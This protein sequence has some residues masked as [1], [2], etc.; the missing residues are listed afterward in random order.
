MKYQKQNALLGQ[1]GAR[2]TYEDLACSNSTKNI[3]AMIEREFPWWGELHGWWCTNPAYNSTW[4]AAD[5]GQNFTRCA[6][7]LFKLWPNPPSGDFIDPAAGPLNSSQLE[8]G[9]IVEG[10][11]DF[12]TNDNFFADD[13]ELMNVDVFACTPPSFN[14]SELSAVISSPSSTFNRVNSISLN[15][16]PP[17]FISHCPKLQPACLSLKQDQPLLKHWSASTPNTDDSSN[18]DIASSNLFSALCLSSSSPSSITALSDDSNSKLSSKPSHKCAWETPADK[19]S[20]DL[21]SASLTFIKQFQQVWQD[22][23][24]VKC[25]WLEYRYWRTHQ[26]ATALSANHEH[27]LTMQC[28]LFTHEEMMVAQELEKMKLTIKL[29]ELHAQNLALQKGI[30]GSEDQG[31][32]SSNQDVYLL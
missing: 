2:H 10:G 26:K 31:P 19:L 6:V 28:E 8:E 1:T 18:S 16:D 15:D 4:S 13:L 23:S 14:F 24:E 11:D 21:A 12:H 22:R 3:I 32:L 27:Q 17:P 20:L 7:E 9:E 30:D 29:E 25:H 5:S